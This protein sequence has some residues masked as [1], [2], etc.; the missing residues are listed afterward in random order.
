MPLPSEQ[1]LRDYYAEDYRK[2]YHGDAVPNPRR[3]MRAWHN[4]ERIYQQVSPFLPRHADV[5]E[6][7]AGIGCT[8]KVFETH[9]INASG[10][11]PN[12]EFNAYTQSVLHAHVEN[13]NLYDLKATQQHDAV[14]LIHVI[15][16][17][18]EPL[19]ALRTIARLLRNDGTLYIECPNLSAPFATF[20]RLFHFAHI[21]NFTHH[22]LIQMAQMAGFEVVKIFSSEDEPDIQILFQ[23]SATVPSPKWDTAEAQRIH[24]AIHQYGTLCYHMRGNYLRRRISKI[25]SYLDEIRHAK[26]FVRVLEANFN[27]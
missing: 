19:K 15:E 17:F 22:T 2:D 6:V 20:D 18:R 12:H 11:E 24:Q 16:H 7:G 9:G 26:A 21:Y 14:L 23:K 10:T 27:P 8:V 25:L 1:A 3:I 4:G 5:F 13:T